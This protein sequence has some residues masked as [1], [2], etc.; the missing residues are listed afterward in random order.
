[1]TEKSFIP[2][3]DGFFHQLADKKRVFAAA[4]QKA[5]NAGREDVLR[6]IGKSVLDEDDFV[7]LTS[8]AAS[9]ELEALAERALSET[10]RRFGRAKQLFAPL[11]LSNYCTNS[12]VYC[13]FHAGPG[14]KR[15]AL[16]PDEIETELKALAATG[17]RQVL[18]LT[19]DAPKRT[20]GSYIALAVDMA[21]RYFPTVG[22]EVPAL[23]LEEYAQ[24]AKAGAGSMTMFQET[25][26]QRLYARLHPAGPKRVF[27]NRLDAPHRALMAGIRQVNF[28]VLLGL[29]D[30]RFDVFMMA[31]HA[32]FLQRMF[33]EA[34]TAF[35]LPRLRPIGERKN[36][37]DENGRV[38]V[39]SPV[40]DRD[41]VQALTALRCFVPQAG[42]TLS[43]RE[44]AFM[45]DRLLPLGVTKI[46]AGV[47]TGVGG[48][49]QPA[50]EKTVQFFI[51]DERSVDEMRDS[52]GKL[53]FQ[54]VFSDWLLPEKGE[55]PLSQALRRSLGDLGH[56]KSRAPF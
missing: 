31:A 38:F 34:E 56:H 9:R 21:A 13:G 5:E 30:W 33:P 41:F 15:K 55:L 1:M 20:G 47:C 19:G 24:I 6:A 16:S 12:C 49:A 26:D 23:T 17:L 29:G 36:G 2:L 50:P 51:D 3:G 4:A 39:P 37:G 45:R 7:L 53:G 28:G 40:K 27:A 25:Y 44:S 35:S 32:R 11:Y 8:P 43:T 46:S 10:L 22:I 48:Y 42:I 14:I 18:L 52:L 54:P